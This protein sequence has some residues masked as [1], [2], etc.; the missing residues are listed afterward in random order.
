MHTAREHRVVYVA[1][2]AE[3]VYVLHA[4]AKETAKTARRDVK[5]ARVRFQALLAGK[6]VTHAM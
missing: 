4:F 3:T 2:F 6:R 5:L 1:T